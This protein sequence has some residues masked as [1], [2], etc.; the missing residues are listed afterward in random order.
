M[1]E[2]YQTIVLTFVWCF[3]EFFSNFGTIESVEVMLDKETGKKRGFG[4]MTFDCHDTVDKLVSKWTNLK[5]FLPIYF[6]IVK[7]TF[8]LDKRSFTVND[9]P[10]EVKKALSRSEMDKAKSDGTYILLFYYTID[11]STVVAYI[12]WWR[13]KSV[14]SYTTSVPSYTPHQLKNKF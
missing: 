6:M 4:F 12:F 14:P 11:T 8:D 2:K 3:K 10:I 13:S 1:N 9:I 7:F 5:M